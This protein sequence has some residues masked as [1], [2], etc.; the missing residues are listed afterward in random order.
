MES[1]SAG[2]QV[3]IKVCHLGFFTNVCDIFRVPRH[4][5]GWRGPKHVSDLVLD[6]PAPSV[7]HVRY[8][9][10]VPNNQSEAIQPTEYPI[11]N[12]FQIYI[13]VHIRSHCFPSSKV[14]FLLDVIQTFEHVS[15]F[16]DKWIRSDSAHDFR[17]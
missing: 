2:L 15:V 3:T 8:N 4:F 7:Q 14:D 16:F 11:F 13:R 12:T 17:S 6:P 5:V 1:C 9:W 10:A